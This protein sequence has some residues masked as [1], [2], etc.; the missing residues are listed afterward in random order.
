M[1]DCNDRA[2][3][4]GIFV[5]ELTAFDFDEAPVEIAQPRTALRMASQPHRRVPFSRASI[6]IMR[7]S[8]DKRH[9]FPSTSGAVSREGKDCSIQAFS[10]NGVSAPHPGDNPSVIAAA[11]RSN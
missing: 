4:L 8:I 1:F 10:P 3:S 9:G 5:K 11:A 6:A 7:E 2:A